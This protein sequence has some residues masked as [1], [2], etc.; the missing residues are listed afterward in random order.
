MIINLAD[1]QAI[2]IWA[3]M[4]GEKFGKFADGDLN[5]EMILQITPSCI[6]KFNLKYDKGPN[7]GSR[8][9]GALS[10]ISKLP[11]FVFGN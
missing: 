4:D 7:F 5:G 10:F 6:E 8:S 1:G 9:L 11:K 3:N 2:W